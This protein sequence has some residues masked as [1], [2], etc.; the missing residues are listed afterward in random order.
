MTLNHFFVETNKTES[1][2]VNVRSDC[3]YDYDGGC[4]CGCGFVDVTNL[5]DDQPDSDA[6]TIFF[7][8]VKNSTV[9]NYGEKLITA[10]NESP[11]F[12]MILLVLL[13][14]VLL[15]MLMM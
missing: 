3:D 2:N 15:L 14:M 5:F 8:F 9:A 6:V 10:S 7:D 4:G 13:L 12:L 1:A 11:M